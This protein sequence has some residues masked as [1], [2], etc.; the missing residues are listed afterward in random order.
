MD[1][2]DGFAS[3][4]RLTTNGSIPP[5]EVNRMAKQARELAQR[6]IIARDIDLMISRSENFQSGQQ[7]GIRNKFSSYLNSTKGQNLKKFDPVMYAAMQRASKGTVVT[8]LASHLGRYGIDPTKGGNIAALLSLGGSGYMAYNGNPEAAA[9]L[10]AAGTA[11]KFGSRKAALRF[12]EDAKKVALAGRNAR[13]SVGTAVKARN[14]ATA[15]TAGLSANQ[16]RGGG[17][18]SAAW[19]E[20]AF[21]QDAKG[22]FFD[23]NGR[24]IPAAQ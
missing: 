6:T 7:S 20:N 1:A 12:A 10:L 19:P 23:R 17:D 16:S 15:A 13:K 22:R 18:R 24:L 9:A 2:L 11:A 4:A 21:L 8:N 5:N 3:A 14:T